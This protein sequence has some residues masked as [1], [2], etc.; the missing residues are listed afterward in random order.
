MPRFTVDAW[1]ELADVGVTHALTVPTML[2]MLLDAGRLA[3]PTLRVLQ[4]GASPIHPATLRCT[5]EALTDVGLVNLFGQTEGSP[6]TCLGPAD[7]RRI[8][9]EGRD[10][11]LESVGRA[12]PGL[13]LVIDEPDPAGVGEVLARANHLLLPGPD[14]WL[15]TG[16]LG[17]LDEEGYLFLSGRRGDKIIRGGENIYPI[18]VEQVLERHP[19]VREAAVIAVPDQRWG[20]LVKAVIVPTDPSAPPDPEDLRAHVRAQLAGFKVPVQWATVEE[21]PRNASGKLLRRAIESVR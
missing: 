15:H 3:L 7:H 10:D 8:A 20:E 12:V 14:G 17:R 19:G 13:E 1:T 2:E 9:A 21:L 5:L 6:I 4:Y 11:L 16:D 18:E